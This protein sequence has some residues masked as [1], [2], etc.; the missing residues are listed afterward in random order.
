VAG[1]LVVLSDL[2]S[3]VALLTVDSLLLAAALAGCSRFGDRQATQLE[4]LATEWFGEWFLTAFPVRRRRIRDVSQEPISTM[5]LTVRSYLEESRR[6]TSTFIRTAC[7]GIAAFFEAAAMGEVVWRVAYEGRGPSA[8]AWAAAVVSVAVFCTAW[9]DL[10]RGRSRRF[11]RVWRTEAWADSYQPE[12]LPTIVPSALV[13]LV[14]LVPFAVG[15]LIWTAD[16]ASWS[17]RVGAAGLVIAIWASAWKH[18]DSDA[19]GRLERRLAP[20]SALAAKLVPSHM[21]ECSAGLC[22]DRDSRPRLRG[23]VRFI[24]TGL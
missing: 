5:E 7:S 11:P 13:L 19:I 14:V 4:S 18:R 9:W 3:A 10:R 17:G 16:S 15:D 22:S 23:Y 20:L 21:V 2:P 8:V 12:P 24:P 6:R 1:H